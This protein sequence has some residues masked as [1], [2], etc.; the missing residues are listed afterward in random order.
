MR[1]EKITVAQNGFIMEDV[2]GNL[3]IAKTL[4]EAAQIAG[5]EVLIKRVTTYAP[6]SGYTDLIR[7]KQEAMAGRKFDAIKLLRDTFTPRL[8]LREAK[9]MV[10]RLCG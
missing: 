10:E 5:E 2:H 7:V 1:L 3:H 8:S 4:N 9:D 6:G